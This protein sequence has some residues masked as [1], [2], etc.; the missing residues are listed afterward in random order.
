M[1]VKNTHFKCLKSYYR[2]SRVKLTHLF[3]ECIS[4]ILISFEISTQFGEIVILCLNIIF[5]FNI[6][7]YKCMF[8]SS[9]I[10]N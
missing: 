2:D 9:D 8:Y 10:I 7:N 4:K 6:F 3:L 1:C 5:L